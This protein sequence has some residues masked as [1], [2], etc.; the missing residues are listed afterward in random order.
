MSR[1]SEISNFCPLVL[2]GILSVHPVEHIEKSKF[3]ISKLPTYFTITFEN[4]LFAPFKR[5]NI[6]NQTV[7]HAMV[8]ASTLTAQAMINTNMMI[9]INIYF[10][11][12]KMSASCPKMILPQM[13]AIPLTST[14]QVISASLRPWDW[15]RSTLKVNPP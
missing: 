3:L 5:P 4:V 9:V 2:N 7:C 11:G 12:P 8:V 13:L 6:P 15:A 10:L 1:R 14:S